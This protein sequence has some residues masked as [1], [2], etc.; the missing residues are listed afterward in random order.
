MLPSDIIYSDLEA[1]WQSLP[2]TIL[3]R[4]R[5]VELPLAQW[6]AERQACHAGTFLLGVNGPQGCGKST[7]SEALKTI[8]EIYYGLRVVEVS[9]D[10]FYLTRQER[11]QLADS[12]HPLFRTRGVPGT[13]DTQLAINT[14][15]ILMQSNGSVAVPR[16]NKAADDR[17]SEDHWTYVQ[18][19]VDVILFEGWCVGAQPVP[20]ETLSSPLNALEQKEDSEGSW[21]SYVNQALAA[22]YQTLFAKLDALVCFRFGDFSWVLDWR[23]EQE[24]QNKKRAQEIGLS[25]RGI[26]DDEA[27]ARF[28][29]HYERVTRACQKILPKTADVCIPISKGRE[30]SE[31]QWKGQV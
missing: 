2:T 22:D 31:L 14:L 3:K 10:D 19:P 7:T 23:T 18:T 26:M 27:L 29:L 20:S 17:F 28:V 13:H 30:V 21:R 9:I 11:E 24:A 1:S 5:T 15:D 6:I 25:T 8:L 16:F 12:V 4:L